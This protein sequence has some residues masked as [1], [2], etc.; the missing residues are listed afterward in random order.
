MGLDLAQRRV[1]V[2]AA[3]RLSWVGRRIAG[4]KG[5]ALAHDHRGDLDGWIDRCVKETEEYRGWVNGGMGGWMDRK[6]DVIDRE[7]Y[8]RTV[9]RTERA[10]R[11]GVTPSYSICQSI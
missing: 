8:V 11:V 1:G 5:V 6:I 4:E 2:G 3:E 9:D 7:S 10:I